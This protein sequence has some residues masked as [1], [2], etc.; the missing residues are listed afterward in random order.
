MKTV[1]GQHNGREKQNAE[2]LGQDPVPEV[3]LLVH[4]VGSRPAS[5]AALRR[6]CHAHPLGGS[7]CPETYT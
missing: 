4:A 3:G 2:T 1:R 6:R 5:S 7:F